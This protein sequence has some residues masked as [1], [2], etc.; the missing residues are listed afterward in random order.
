MNLSNQEDG[1]ETIQVDDEYMNNTFGIG[2]WSGAN[3]KEAAADLKAWMEREA[4]RNAAT[5][6]DGP[7]LVVAAH[8]DVSP[9]TH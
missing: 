9:D 6:V 7:L 1:M 4:I 8:L 5:K 2:Q 3:R